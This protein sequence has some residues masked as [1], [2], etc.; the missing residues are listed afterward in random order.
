[1]KTKLVVSVIGRSIAILY[2]SGV[3]RQPQYG[4]W[5]SFDATLLTLE[6]PPTSDHSVTQKILPGTFTTLFVSDR[7]GLLWTDDLLPDPRVLHVS[8]FA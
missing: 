4:T 7:R 3:Q 6:L 1:M 8:P 2:W 5:S